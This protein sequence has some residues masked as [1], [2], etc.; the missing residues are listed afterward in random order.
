MLNHRRDDLRNDA[1]KWHNFGA[2]AREWA[3][4]ARIVTGQA[5]LT[6]A[7]LAL[8]IAAVVLIVIAIAWLEHRWLT[9]RRLAALTRARA[10]RR[11]A[12]AFI[13]AGAANPPVM[14]SRIAYQPRGPWIVSL[15]ETPAG[16]LY[17]L[18][19]RGRPVED[20]AQHMDAVAVE[21]GTRECKIIPNQGD[22]SRPWMH[23]I[24]RDP[25]DDIDTTLVPP[26]IRPITS[27]L[28]DCAPSSLHDGTPLGIDETGEL[29]RVWLVDRHILIAGATGA[30]KSNALNLIL[31]H[32]A[33]DVNC[34]LWLCD[35]KSGV[36]LGPWRDCAVE[37]VTNSDEPEDAIQMLRTLQSICD[38][39]YAKFEKDRRRKISKTDRV[40]MLVI[41]E[42]A[43]WLQEMQGDGEKE[44]T[45]LRKDFRS[46]L[47]D[48]VARGRSAGII[49]VLGTQ[50]PSVELI[51]SAIRSNVT[52]RIAFR[53]NARELSDMILGG[54]YANHE[55][56]RFNAALID[57]RQRGVGYIKAE[58]GLPKLTRTHRL[59]DDDIDT[60]AAAATELRTAH[61]CQ[62]ESEKAREAQTDQAQDPASE[63]PEAEGQADETSPNAN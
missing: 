54:S 49:V 10:R 14:R 46:V 59:E 24:E 13:D 5:G 38:Q 28:V 61:T 25:F 9:T 37:I 27:P 58:T 31:A 1:D 42:L 21:L 3:V 47:R 2:A 51:D 62:R 55:L 35:G 34:G 60:I 36:E 20:L 8:P 17:E 57:D 50:H 26:M 16:V 63:A 56:G 7:C 43:Y 15:R 12:R 18:K 11:L 53:V 4:E 32:A 33:M 23:V 6:F 22:Q 39:R 19:V 41:D 52:Y 44:T 48:L 45:A 40:H 29:V 30:G